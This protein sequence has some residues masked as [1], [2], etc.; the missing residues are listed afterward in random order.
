[1]HGLNFEMATFKSP[2]QSRKRG[3]SGGKK[4]QGG[5]KTNQLD[6][7]IAIDHELATIIS[8]CQGEREKKKKGKIKRGIIGKG[9]MALLDRIR[10][11][12]EPLFQ[13][14]LRDS[15]RGKGGRPERRGGRGCDLRSVPFTFVP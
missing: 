4:G 11:S 3:D 9:G 5:K 13:D 2:V 8:G 12:H 14:F 1:L 7:F 10:D 6:W 15:K